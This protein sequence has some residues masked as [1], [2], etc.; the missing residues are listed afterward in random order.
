MVAGDRSVALRRNE[1]YSDH[2][3]TLRIGNA[4]YHLPQHSRTANKHANRY[5]LLCTM[6]EETVEG[7]RALSWMPSALPF[8]VSACASSN[9]VAEAF[10]GA[11]LLSQNL[12]FCK[13]MSAPS[14]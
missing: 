1:A 13:G 7:M 10:A 8:F 6:R 5:D 11:V 4:A 9:R 2:P 14:N 3:R 12:F